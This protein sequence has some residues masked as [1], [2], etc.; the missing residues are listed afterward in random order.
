MAAISGTPAIGGPTVGFYGGINY[1]F[2]YFGVGFVGGHWDHDHFFY[3][4][5]V[6]NFG[7]VHITNVYNAPVRNVSAT[8]VSFNGG[9]GGIERPSDGA[10]GSG[11]ARASL[12]PD[13][14]ADPA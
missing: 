4:R 9:R 5:T 2:G 12:G 13:R 8:H 1:G 3:N 10:T 11:R 7:H 6:N 14:R